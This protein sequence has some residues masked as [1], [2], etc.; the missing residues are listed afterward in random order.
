MPS[1]QR[2]LADVNNAVA[3][4][5]VSATA[6]R[7][8]VRQVYRQ[9][10]QRTGY[11][12]VR[13]TGD[14]TGADDATFD[15]EIRPPTTGNERVTQPEFR[16]AG[17]GTLTGASAAPGTAAQTVTVTCVDLG[18][19]TTAA[20]AIIY[21]DILLRARIA[22][23]G[24]NSI[25]LGIVPNL[26][27][28]ATPIGAL[29][30]E[31]ARDTQEWSDQRLDFG[32][33]ALNPDGTLSD[34]SPRLVFGRDTSRVYRHY[35]R[36]DGEQWQYGVSPKLNA[37]Y[38]SGAQVHAVTGNY[39]VTV[40]NG[41]TTESIAGTTLY[42]ILLALSAS[43][44]IEVAGVIAN[45]RRPGGQ[46]AID[47]P[48][49]TNAFALPVVKARE[50]MPDLTGLAV[51]ATAPTEVIK[52]SCINNDA[53]N[54][55]LWAVES[56][57][58]G[59]L[60]VATTGIPYDGAVV[61]FT[62]AKGS[63]SD[64]PLAGSIS[65]AGTDLQGTGDPKAYPSICLHKPALG[66]NASGKTLTLVWTQRPA[67]DCACTDMTV[68][69]RPR[70]DL[71]GIDLGD[72]NAMST[73]VAGHQSRLEALANWH[74]T[75]V[76]GNTNITASGELRTADLDLQL[77][78]LAADELID[79]LADLYGADA[80]LQSP[81]RANTTA[82]ALYTV[83]E[84]ATRNNYRYRC[85]TA[86]T[87][88]SS[89][90]TWPTTVGQT[91]T[92]GTVTWTC[93]SK[94]AEIAWDDVFN[95]LS[96]DLSSLAT[97]GTE[98]AV[99]FKIFPGAATA[100]VLGDVVVTSSNGIYTDNYYRVV[101]S[102]TSTT[103][104]TE[105]TAI[106]AQGKSGTVFYE[107]ISKEEAYALK[108]GEAADINSSMSMWDDPA[109]LRDPTA[110]A[111]RYLAACNHVRAIAGLDLKKADAGLFP[112]AGSDVWTDPGDPY[113]WVIEGTAYL[114]VFN[115]LYYH[116]CKR[117]CG[118][119]P[120]ETAIAPTYEFGFAIQV[121]CP[122]RLVEGDKITIVLNVDAAGR[123]YLVGD[124]YEIPIVM[125]GPLAFSGGVTGTDTLT[126]TVYGST[127]GALPNYA[128]TLAEPAYSGGGLGFT[129]HRGGLAFALGD[130][131]TFAVEIGGRFRW[132]KD[133]GAWS[134]T[135]NIAASVVLADGLSAAFIEGKAPSFVAG[136][137]H[138]FLA[139]QP[140]SPYH[141]RV[142]DETEWRWPAASASLTLTFGA[143]TSM[144]CVGILRHDLPAG[145]TVTMT[146][147]DHLAQPLAV[148]VLTA[149]SGPLLYFL[150]AA[151]TASSLVVAVTGATD[152]ALGWVYAGTPWA[153]THSADQ[154]VLRRSYAMERGGGVNPRGAYLGAGRDGEL[155]WN[156]WFMPADW[157]SL[158]AILD[159]SKRNGDRPVVVTPNLT[160]LQDA[161]L[162][163]FAA[164]TLEVT[165]EYR[166]HDP[167]ARQM[168]CTVP[169]SAVV[170]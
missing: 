115:G 15:I 92:D 51:A 65:L 50:A 8:A 106:G 4:A 40:T 132:R 59:A 144:S 30:A 42:E 123:P 58:A 117:A 43:T 56:K 163:R 129:I 31:L 81:A 46:A 169:L 36:W 126:W 62:I 111:K 116:A 103:S 135:A 76:T 153:A 33:V 125:G 110:W 21:G 112:V 89:P 86:G 159:S 109:I 147:R 22:G 164:D 133:G 107:R 68:S 25:T 44:L 91:V 142:A 98:A 37:T 101:T 161:A 139:R 64:N 66:A 16:G 7:A 155:T 32:A 26:I 141:V 143:P 71:L 52:L 148:A 29:A 136:D 24:G 70:A 34:A 83:V 17:N 166:F 10:Q 72:D 57:V 154:C 128:L 105:L 88:G 27:L 11:G 79:C 114:P 152:G 60:P 118:A 119:T 80:V 104:W 167:T 6:I 130:A 48:I 39:A 85:T 158:L 38:Q 77:A 19:S 95:G 122:E 162:V 150:P 54:A 87:S 9:A 121:G 160:D 41:I 74:K 18:T 78:Q 137:L 49:R 100:Y 102:G 156:N 108:G 131:F 99:A 120:G 145:A 35:K 97:L 1:C 53:L 63:I 151:V 124:T 113:Y 69:G 138:P 14:Y 127:A 170:I 75:F 2:I 96:I 45:D 90:P 47:L 3:A 23:A 20:Q 82:Y 28:S 157:T 168:T 146:L 93:A 13:L 134:A 149:A 61:D 94:I 12:V 5:S 55:E 67:P 140:Y 165:D 73:L 84:P